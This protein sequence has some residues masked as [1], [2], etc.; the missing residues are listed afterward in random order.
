MIY[1]LILIFIFTVYSSCGGVAAF[2][3]ETKPFAIEELRLHSPNVI[4]FKLVTGR[5]MWHIVG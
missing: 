1:L 2:Y 4:R 5:K 3:S